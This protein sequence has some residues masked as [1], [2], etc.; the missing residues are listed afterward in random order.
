MAG[1]KVLMRARA[2]EFSRETLKRLME[3]VNGE[4]DRPEFVVMVRR[5]LWDAL[6][7]LWEDLEDDK[8]NE[9]DED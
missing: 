5:F 6:D 2:H 1:R 4:R 7:D 9:Y 3:E 8:R